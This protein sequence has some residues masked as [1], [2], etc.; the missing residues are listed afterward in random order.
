MGPHRFLPPWTSRVGGEHGARSLD[1]R[2][3]YLDRV[4]VMRGASGRADPLRREDRFP[5]L[6]SALLR[7][8]GPEREHKL[9][10]TTR[11]TDTELLEP[12]RN[13]LCPRLDERVERIEDDPLAP[14]VGKAHV[15]EPPVS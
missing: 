2:G 15:H 10:P 12:E 13:F 6:R 8:H 4:A 5:K 11:N 1:A 7:A 14:D 3:A 9:A